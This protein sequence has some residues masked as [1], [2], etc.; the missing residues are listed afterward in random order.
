MKFKIGEKLKEMKLVEELRNDIVNPNNKLSD[1]LRKAKILASILK[2]KEFKKWIDNELNGYK[3]EN[4]LPE[5]RVLSTQNFGTFSGSF[6]SGAKNVGVP[7]WKMPDDFQK[8]WSVSKFTNGIRELESLAEEGQQKSLIRKWPAEAVALWNMKYEEDS[9]YNLVGAYSEISKSAIEAIIDTTRNK[10]LDF[11]LEL[12]EFNPEVY[13]SEE[14]ISEL[15]KEEVKNIF[16]YTIYGDNNIVSSGQHVHQNVEQ[17]VF[18]KNFE[19]LSNFLKEKGVSE[20][21]IVNLKKAIQA[22]GE[23]EKDFGQNVKAWIGNMLVKATEGTWKIAVDTASK[24]L[25]AALKSYYEI[26]C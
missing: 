24:L 9:D 7:I 16:N 1:A 4:E 22:D 13:S 8:Q 18:K 20:S 26:Q 25:T 21:D 14:A 5:Y 17:N 10:L 3:N 2:D 12:S 19:S 11:I 15:P 6:G 23:V